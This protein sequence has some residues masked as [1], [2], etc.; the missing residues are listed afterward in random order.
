MNARSIRFRL[1]VWH[2]GLLA[3]SLVLFGVSVYAGLGHCLKRTLTDSLTKE[4]RQIGETLLVN[5]SLSGEAYVVDEIKE[6]LAPEINGVF[7]RVTR[8][9]G[10][11]LYESGL[12]RD[13]SFDPGNVN[14]ARVD[15][16][17]PQSR[18]EHLPGGT[19]MIVCAVPFTARERSVCRCQLQSPF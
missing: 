12:P 15:S 7:V 14:A 4:A 6:H 13:G 5:I 11:S 19:E 18:V 16:T 10:S 8:A 9:D 2:A 3:G 1:T 17:Q